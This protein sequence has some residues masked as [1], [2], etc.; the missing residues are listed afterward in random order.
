MIMLTIVSTLLYLYRTNDYAIEQASAVS[1]AQRGLDHIVREIREAA[2]ASNGAYPIVSFSP[3][4]FVFYADVD[5]DPFIEKVRYFMQGTALKRGVTDPVGDPPQYTSTE[6]VTQLSDNV[7]NVG[8]GVP[9]FVYYDNNGTQITDYT[10]IGDVRFVSVSVQVDVDPS[11][12]PTPFLIRSSAAL[13][14]LQ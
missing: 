2:Y 5:S 13:R 1:S 8:H 12:S 14:N 10:R 4:E 6:V 3:N 7:R 11:R 9:V